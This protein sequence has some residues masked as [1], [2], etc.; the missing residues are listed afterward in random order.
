M[1]N[2]D[3]INSKYHFLFDSINE[4]IPHIIDNK[5]KD[6]ITFIPISL[7]AF[8]LNEPVIGRM[9]NTTQTKS[10][11]KN[12]FNGLVITCLIGYSLITK[13]ENDFVLGCIHI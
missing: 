7:D 1:I 3:A 12:K 6:S 9:K 2:I 8:T 10:I 13:I 4:Y 11:D 5:I